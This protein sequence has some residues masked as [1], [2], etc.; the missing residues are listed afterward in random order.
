MAGHASRWVLSYSRDGWDN[1]RWAAEGVTRR[2]PRCLAT[3][4]HRT[5]RRAEQCLNLSQ[6]RCGPNS[7]GTPPGCCVLAE[8]F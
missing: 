4:N 7:V 8:I 5:T 3:N 2:L 1:R 6:S